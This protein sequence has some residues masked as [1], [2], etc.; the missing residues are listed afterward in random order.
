M[1]TYLIGG[2]TGTG[3]VQ[4]PR[5]SSFPA[6]TSGGMG[7][8]EGAF[9]FGRVLSGFGNVQQN[10]DQASALRRNASQMGITARELDVSKERA[11]NVAIA[12]I[13]PAQASSYAKAGVDISSGSALAVMAQTSL[14][15]FG[16]REALRQ[17]FQNRIDNL[18]FQAR[19]SR[20]QANRLTSP[21]NQIMS[22]VSGIFGG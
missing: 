4:V 14:E 15:A 16:D 20:T 11:L 12:D 17:D 13:V 18:R 8:A 21:A 19:L 1:S 7:F 3:N 10:I 5:T 9:Y 22:F 2:P 6:P